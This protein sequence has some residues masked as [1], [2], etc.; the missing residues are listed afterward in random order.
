MLYYIC[1]AKRLH[2]RQVR[3]RSRHTPI[4]AQSIKLCKGAT[5]LD[6]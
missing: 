2:N 4:S 3:V 6:L 1:N 5:T